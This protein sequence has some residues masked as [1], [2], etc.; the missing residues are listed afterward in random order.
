MEKNCANDLNT[1]SLIYLF[2]TTSMKLTSE[3]INNEI[4]FYYPNQIKIFDGRTLSEY[5]LYWIFKNNCF[6]PYDSGLFIIKKKKKNKP[7]KYW[8]KKF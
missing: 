3:F 5:I 6:Y 4:V 8:D 1:R 7:L 2:Y